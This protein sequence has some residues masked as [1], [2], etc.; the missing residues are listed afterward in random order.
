LIDSDG[1]TYAKYKTSEKEFS[2]IIQDKVNPINASEYQFTSKELYNLDSK[3]IF[4][5]TIKEI[6]TAFNGKVVGQDE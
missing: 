5:E 2:N 1:K 3:L 4:S 6:K